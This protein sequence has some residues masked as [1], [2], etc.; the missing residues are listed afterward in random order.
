MFEL[1]HDN[2][3]V[4]STKTLESAFMKDDLKVNNAYSYSLRNYLMVA[5]MTQCFKKKMLN[6][7]AEE[8]DTSNFQFLAKN[9]LVIA[10]N[11]NYYGLYANIDGVV[12]LVHKLK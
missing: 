4:P 11:G 6:N 5:I 10:C 7:N 2:I 12:C 3:L 1:V 8:I 9:G